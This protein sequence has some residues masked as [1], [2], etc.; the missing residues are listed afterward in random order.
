MVGTNGSSTGQYVAIVGDG[1]F[2]L[3]S[4]LEQPTPQ[5]QPLA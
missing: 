3:G 5:D 2:S 4:L 1:R